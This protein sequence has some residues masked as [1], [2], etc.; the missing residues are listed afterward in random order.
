MLGAVRRADELTIGPSVVLMS[1]LVKRNS[2]WRW[3]AIVAMSGSDCL[4]RR[5]PCLL[6]QRT[7]ECPVF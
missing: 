6:T 1:H 4:E 2:V 5:E 7:T 3:Y